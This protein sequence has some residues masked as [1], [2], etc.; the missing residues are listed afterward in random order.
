MQVGYKGFIC[1]LIAV[2][3]WW[4]GVSESPTEA[5]RSLSGEKLSTWR[6]LP[7]SQVSLQ[8]PPLLFHSFLVSRRPRCESESRSVLSDSLQ[9]HGLY[10]PWNSPGQNTGVGSLSLFQGIFPTEGSNPGLPHCRWI[11]YHLSHQGSPRILKWVTYPFSIRSSQPR[12]QT[13]VSCITVGFFTSWATREALGGL[14]DQEYRSDTVSWSPCTRL[15][16]GCIQLC[17][18]IKGFCWD[19]HNA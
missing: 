15:S 6:K 17:L 19:S 1:S 2:S 7:S 11:L 5:R 8:S 18:A 12:N 4:K 9:P 14:G 16:W 13:R 3:S 10:S